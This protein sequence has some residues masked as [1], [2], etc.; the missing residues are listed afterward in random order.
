MGWKD[1][2]VWKL[3]G[4]KDVV[5]VGPV[6]YQSTDGEITATFEEY[7]LKAVGKEER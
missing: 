5:T 7:E 3:A 2:Y 1:G 6:A 4:L